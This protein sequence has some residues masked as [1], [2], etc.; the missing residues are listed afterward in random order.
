MYI[1]KTFHI[2][3]SKFK[4]TVLSYQQA[5]TAIQ[6]CDKLILL[7]FKAITLVSICAIIPSGAIKQHNKTESLGGMLFVNPSKYNSLAINTSNN[8]KLHHVNVTISAVAKNYANFATSGNC[9]IER[10]SSNTGPNRCYYIAIDNIITYDAIKTPT[11]N[12]DRINFF[13]NYYFG[14]AIINKQIV[15]AKYVVNQKSNSIEIAE[16]IV[17]IVYSKIPEQRTFRPTVALFYVEQLQGQKQ[18][19]VT[20]L[21]DFDL[22]EIVLNFLSEI[23]ADIGQ[24]LRLML[25]DCPIGL[26]N[27]CYVT[28]IYRSLI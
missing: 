15:K 12:Q 25:I 8:N 1:H 26:E 11:G 21:Q 27:I 19:T 23:L 22:I 7:T 16:E 14:K 5:V 28:G 24:Y 10:T 6:G 9:G 18:E 4:L 13:V 2:R 3:S 20:K 17:K